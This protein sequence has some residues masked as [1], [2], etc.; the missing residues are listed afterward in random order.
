MIQLVRLITTIC[1]NYDSDGRNV[2][3]IATPYINRTGGAKTRNS[4]YA[5]SFVST[6]YQGH[7]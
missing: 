7:Y 1:N 2:T 6:Y 3:C 4:A 5:E